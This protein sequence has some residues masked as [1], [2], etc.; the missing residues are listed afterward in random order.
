MALCINHRRL[1]LLQHDFVIYGHVK[2]KRYVL[3]SDTVAPI[4]VTFIVIRFQITHNTSNL[5][6]YK[7]D[8]KIATF[9]YNL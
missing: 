8:F 7:Q 2:Q 3:H 6:L 4:T 9:K 5:L 1:L